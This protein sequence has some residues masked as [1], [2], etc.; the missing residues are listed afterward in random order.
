VLSGKTVVDV[1]RGFGVFGVA[2]V[3]ATAAAASCF[4]AVSPPPSVSAATA[5]GEVGLEIG[6]RRRRF[7]W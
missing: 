6:K 3:S 7:G 5:S 2:R 1:L 4:A